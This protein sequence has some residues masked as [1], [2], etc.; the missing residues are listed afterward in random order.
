MTTLDLAPVALTARTPLPVRPRVLV[1]PVTITPTKPLTP[2]HLKGLLWADVV[3]RATSWVAD[4]THRSSHTVFHPCEQTVGFWEYL[5]RTHGDI[6]YSGMSEDEIG[7]WYVRYRA[8]GDRAPFAACAPYLDAIE[9]HGWVHPASA[10]LLALRAGQ[11]R[12]LGLHDPGLTVHQPPG[13]GLAEAIDRLHTLNLCLDLRANGGPVYLD[14]T[15]D[16]IPLRQIVGQDG[17]PNYLACALR[18]LLPLAAG[19]DEVVLLHDRELTP[20]YLLLQRVLSRLGPSVRRVSLGRVPIDG[21]V[22]S[23]RHGGWR[24]HTAQALLAAFGTRHTPE[25]LRLGMR[26]YFIGVLGPG[27]HDSFRPDLLERHLN[28]AA[29]LL[30]SATDTS[31]DA[32]FSWLATYRDPRTDDPLHMDAYRLT[33]GLLGRRARTPPYALLAQVF[34]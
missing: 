19:Y 9:R 11:Y 12:Q 34:T 27:E 3:H 4:A 21:R 28:R 13:I 24:Q 26:L 32:L 8:D 18:D 1:A 10:R 31:A 16:G 17:R 30:A 25:A 14:A 15:R 33:A 20:D 6:D 22:T 5:D 23:A 29:K 7:E 2:S